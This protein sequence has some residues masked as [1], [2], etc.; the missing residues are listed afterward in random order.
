MARFFERLPLLR[1]SLPWIL[2][3]LSLTLNVFF[4]GGYYY[5]RALDQRLSGSEQER[6]RYVVEQLRFDSDQRQRFQEFRQ[7][8]RERQRETSRANR[9]VIE[10]LWREIEKPEPDPKQL[11]GYIER[12]TTNRLTSQREQMNDLMRFAKTLDE[13]QRVEF[14]ELVRTRLERGAM[15][16][17]RPDAR[18]DR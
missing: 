1:A 17:R 12:L 2:C 3:A 11:D 4:L 6:G 8:A 5:K 14:L 16:P 9:P 18:P 10:S 7:R 13:K 15:F